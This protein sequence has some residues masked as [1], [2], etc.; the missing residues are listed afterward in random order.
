MQSLAGRPPQTKAKNSLPGWPGQYDV[1]PP[2]RPQFVR[3]V[4][5]HRRTRE[6][7]PPVQS[8]TWLTAQRNEVCTRKRR[9]IRKTSDGL[10]TVNVP[11]EPRH[12][13]THN[14]RHFRRTDGFKTAKFTKNATSATNATFTH[15]CA[16]HIS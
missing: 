10:L 2:K 7:W 1:M 13:T 5:Q 4:C 14:R 6:Q 16:K 8:P 11:N 12:A 3:A 9:T 15:A